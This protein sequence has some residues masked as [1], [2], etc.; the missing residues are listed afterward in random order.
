MRPRINSRSKG[1]RGELEFCKWL[2][3]N[4]GLDFLPQ[5]NL[6]QVREGGSHIIQFPPFYFE[7]KRVE[8]LDHFKAWS[9]VV[10]SAMESARKAGTFQEG[11]LL[12][13]T[14][15]IIPIV[16]FRTNATKWEF[17]IPSQFIGM[18][19]GYVRLHES[20][21]IRWARKQ[22]AESQYRAEDDA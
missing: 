7:V 12:D 1:I 4:F 5:R 11:E 13:N 20:M 6:E 10:F 8:G 3:R 2:Q 22:I 19:M 14:G 17:L 9:Q 21:F 16:S 18:E 15:M